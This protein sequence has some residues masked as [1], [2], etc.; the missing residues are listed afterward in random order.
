MAELAIRDDRSKQ[1]AEIVRAA[2]PEAEATEF[3]QGPFYMQVG[4]LCTESQQRD[5]VEWWITAAAG[6]C[7]TRLH[8]LTMLA[9]SPHKCRPALQ[10]VTSDSQPEMGDLR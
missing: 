10:L 6:F 4:N 9:G 2:L 7:M 8:A 5:Q 3:I 1:A